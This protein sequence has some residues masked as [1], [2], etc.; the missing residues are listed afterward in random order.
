[1]SARLRS[2]AEYY[3]KYLLVHP[4]QYDTP[5]IKERLLDEGLDFLHESYVEKLRLSLKPP[6]PFYPM[7]AG[8]LASSRFI[9]KHRMNSLFQRTVPMKMALQVLETPRAKEFVESMLLV[10]VPMTAIAV[11]VSKHHRLHCTVE[12][13]ELYRHYFWNIDLLDSSQMRVLLQL[14]T[15]LAEESTPYLKGRKKLLQNA[16]YKDARKVAADLPYSPTTA[17]LAQMR[18]GIKP[19]KFDLALRMMEARD[20]AIMRVV[21]SIQQDG[22]MDSQ[23]TL[24]Y[25]NT[26]RVLEELLQMVVRPEDGMREQLRSIALRTETRMLPYVHELSGGNHTVDISP[27]KDPNHDEPAEVAVEE[28]GSSK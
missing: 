1:M 6:K 18:L 27:L 2:P 4:D 7:E 17:T 28:P 26:S 24:N 20:S 9:L 14:R 23:K 11:F 13:L 8:H 16:Y 19:G 5:T 3:I 15:E 25:A 21:E 22:P 12:A 10:Q